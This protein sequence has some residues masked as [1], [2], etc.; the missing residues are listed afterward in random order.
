MDINNKT[1]GSDKILSS[2]LEKAMT[3]FFP[4][5]EE[6]PKT[7]SLACC[8]SHV[9]VCVDNFLIIYKKQENS[10]QIDFSVELP[11]KIAPN[12]RFNDID[13]SESL[14]LAAYSNEILTIIRILPNT[15][16]KTFITGV[17]ILLWD[18]IQQNS[19]FTA[20]SSNTLQHC[21]LNINLL[22]QITIGIDWTCKFD[23]PIKQLLIPKNSPNSIFVLLENGSLHYY[24]R[25]SNSNK[26]RLIRDM[27]IEIEGEKIIDIGD[28]FSDFIIFMTEHVLC[29]Y[30]ILKFKICSV[31]T[32]TGNYSSFKKIYSIPEYPFK[33]FILTNHRTLIHWDFCFETGAYKVMP[34]PYKFMTKSSEVVDTICPSEEGFYYISDKHR[35]LHLNIIN[36]EI[37]IKESILIPIA[38]NIKLISTV[39]NN[40]AFTNDMAQLCIADNGNI[41]NILNQDEKIIGISYPDKESIYYVTE[42][43]LMKMSISPIIVQKQILSSSFIDSSKLIHFKDMKTSGPFIAVRIGEHR[44]FVMNTKEDKQTYLY[45]YE[46]LVD[47][48]ITEMEESL[49][50]L[51]IGL[52]GKKTLIVDQNYVILSTIYTDIT[53]AS[54]TIEFDNQLI[55]VKKNGSLI[56]QN[57]TYRFTY[58]PYHS[59]AC[60]NYRTKSVC[61]TTSSAVVVYS[62]ITDSLQEVFNIPDPDST[63]ISFDGNTI[64]YITKSF[65]VKQ[66]SIAEKSSD[67]MRIENEVKHRWLKTP[68]SDLNLTKQSLIVGASILEKC[69]QTPDDVSE[70]RYFFGLKQ[71]PSPM[72]SREST[73]KLYRGIFMSLKDISISQD[74]IDQINAVSDIWSK[75]SRFINAAVMQHFVGDK[76]KAALSLMQM[77]QYEL[78]AAYANENNFADIAKKAACMYAFQR[79]NKG[80]NVEAASILV[81]YNEYHAACHVLYSAQL[82]DKMK[83]CALEAINIDVLTQCELD[84][85]ITNCDIV[86]LDEILRMCNRRKF[87]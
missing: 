49:F 70:I 54:S 59:S 3:L 44:I 65:A 20:T 82:F 14:Y 74:Q 83:F 34:N 35:I 28:S 23:H 21:V 72:M 8:S 31:I 39:D 5:K 53:D 6:S 43:Q 16:L 69:D 66:T 12:L 86:S 37:T 26:F 38:N 2:K 30:H 17:N 85:T 80:M 62:L 87:N 13:Y 77:K 81:N 64:N 76:E 48:M 24:Q 36:N 55:I 1:N 22:N 42:N 71:V 51:T 32:L 40:F 41:K 63:I 58:L 52:K 67:K 45:F 15:I 50:V 18:M 56:S 9:A 84:K 47:Y 60:Y 29:F 4:V 11:E 61:I 75:S 25:S 27:N 78:S 19:M 33:F 57:K 73:S 10:Y 46:D 79:A 7:Y 68:F